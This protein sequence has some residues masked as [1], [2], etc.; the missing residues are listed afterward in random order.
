MS[1]TFQTS[2]KYPGW[3]ILKT[4]PGAWLMGHEATKAKVEVRELTG[5]F[6]AWVVRETTGGR[7]VKTRVW[8]HGG[9]AVR[10]ACEEATW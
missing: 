2:N 10:R 5:G 9:N 3:L 6:G 8:T 1:A 7:L 4:G